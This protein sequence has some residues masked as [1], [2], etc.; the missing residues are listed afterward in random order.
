LAAFRASVRR[1]FKNEP[2][3][4]D[5]YVTLSDAPGFGLE[6][7]REANKLTRPFPRPARDFKAIEAEKDARTPEQGEWLLRAGKI[8]VTKSA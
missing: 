2:L 4:V 1:S 3:P 6:L 8:P 7:N 5:G